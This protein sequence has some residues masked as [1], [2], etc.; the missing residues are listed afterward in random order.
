MAK[1]QGGERQKKTVE[2]SWRQG[3]IERR[4]RNGKMRSETAE[5]MGAGI[6]FPAVFIL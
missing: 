3:W 6:S 4:M 2:T 1:R 5:E